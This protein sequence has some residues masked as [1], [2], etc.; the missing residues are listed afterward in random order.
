MGTDIHMMVERFNPQKHQWEAVK[1][2]P[3]KH[4]L[5][6]E[7]YKRDLERGYSAKDSYWIRVWKGMREQGG[8]YKWLYDA[9]NYDL[10]AI[11]ANVRN[12]RGFAGV[13]TGE[14]FKPIAY[15]RGVPA[16]ASPEYQQ[17]VEEW[18][19]DGHSHSYLTLRELLEYDWHGQKTIK[20]GIVS[21]QEY[22]EFLKTGKPNSYC[23]DIYGQDIVVVSPAFMDRILK[24]DSPRDPEKR[25]YVRISWEVTY[26]EAA[27]VFVDECISALKQLVEDNLT[28][29]D[30]RIVFFFD[31]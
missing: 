20:Y 29:D 25:Y 1:R 18:G 28:Y 7:A 8:T 6:F 23:G 21:E 26:Y 11:L 31:N 5:Y 16:D 13:I 17:Y 9:R 19:V 15:P 24:D 27:K 30:V 12:G 10:F 3:I 2:M 22:L 4:S 14:G